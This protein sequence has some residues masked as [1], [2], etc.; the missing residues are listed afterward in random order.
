MWNLLCLRKP[1][2]ESKNSALIGCR[3][4]FPARGDQLII[5]ETLKP[6]GVSKTDNC[7]KLTTPLESFKMYHHEGEALQRV[8]LVGLDSTC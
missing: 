1:C 4:A 3:Q 8:M 5:P 6:L 7:E 2:S